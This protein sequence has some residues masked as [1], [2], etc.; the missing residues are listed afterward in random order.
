MNRFRGFVRAGSMWIP[1]GFA[2][3][4]PLAVSGCLEPRQK[5]PPEEQAECGACHGGMLPQAF[6]GA[7]PYNL[8][9]DT[10][11]SAR[12]NGAHEAHLVG[13]DRARAVACSECH[14]VPESVDSPG[15]MDDPYP[16]EV[17]FQGPAKAF[18]AEPLF[19]ADKGSCQNT[20]C[21]GGSFV[22]GRDSGG[23]LTEPRWTDVS[24][25]PAAC[26]ACHGLPPPLPHPLEEVCSDCHKNI[27][28]DRTFS[29][30]DLHVDG[31]VNFNLPSHVDP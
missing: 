29:H 24:Q 20:F 18:E 3:G 9:G 23:T 19:D 16:V 27:R 15:H 21:H 12:G 14:L 11:P 2:L 10:E 13:R 7:P 28:E 8:S 17:L 6:V 4:V 1:L 30:P 26:G 25:E 5:G 31:V 22:G